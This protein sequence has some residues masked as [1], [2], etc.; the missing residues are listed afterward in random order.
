MD[1]KNWIAA[2]SMLLVVSFSA[3]TGGGA[4]EGDSYFADGN[5]EKAIGA[6]D[7]FLTND[8]KNVKVLYNR[9]RSYEELGDFAN[10]EKDF[11]KALESDSKNI[12]VLMSLSNV[13]QKQKNHSAALLYADYAVEIP[14]APAMAYF[15]K[16]RALHQLGN[17]DEALRE[18][19]AAIKMDKD[20]G[21]AFYYRGLLKIATKSKKSGCE[22]LNLALKMN[23]EA[24]KEVIEK[25][26]Q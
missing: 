23:F 22:D 10:A 26:C 16:G 25:Y 19:S 11:L 20:F 9:G 13:Y 15:L 14:G 1:F 7:K 8:P 4:K 5:Y 21:Q 18:Y 2:F 24:A 6:Y 3:C 17:T 12:Q